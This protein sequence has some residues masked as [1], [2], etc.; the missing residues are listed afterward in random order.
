MGSFSGFINNLVSSQDMNVALG[1]QRQGATMDQ[2]LSQMANDIQAALEFT[3][4]NGKKGKAGPK[5]NNL[6]RLAAMRRFFEPKC[7]ITL[8]INDAK[9]GINLNGLKDIGSIDPNIKTYANLFNKLKS[10][11]SKS[12][13]SNSTSL[14]QDVEQCITQASNQMEAIPFDISFPVENRT[15]LDS[16]FRGT[17]VSAIKNKQITYSQGVTVPTIKFDINYGGNRCTKVK[18]WIL[19]GV[20][21]ANQ[22]TRDIKSYNRRRKQEV[23]YVSKIIPAFAQIAYDA[24][25]LGLNMRSSERPSTTECNLFLNTVVTSG[26]TTQILSNETRGKGYVRLNWFMPDANCMCGNTTNTTFCKTLLSDTDDYITLSRALNIVGI[27]SYKGNATTISEC[28]RRMEKAYGALL[29]HEF[30]HAIIHSN[31]T[32]AFTI[33]DCGSKNWFNEGF[34]ELLRGKIY[35]GLNSITGYTFGIFEKLV[36]GSANQKDIK[37]YI[38]QMLK[39]H[40]YTMGYILLKYID[41]YVK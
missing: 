11:F 10:E 9:T 24:I 29:C 40:N 5:S 8:P 19:A 20:N 31:H 4:S 7:N 6:T 1:S 15:A 33:Q 25:G 21:D 35:Q 26:H 18:L 36:I 22:I 14:E 37:A 41:V 13:Y 2:V 3:N 12:C 23:Y 28:S 39:D 16:K 27:S 32:K 38:K 34:A 17:G 30:M